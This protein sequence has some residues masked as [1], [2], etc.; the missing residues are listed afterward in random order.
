MDSQ[1]DK[2][3]STLLEVLAK[4]DVRKAAFFGSLVT[5]EATEDSDVDLLVEFEG[6]KSLLD[7]AGLKIELEEMLGRDVDVVTYASLHPLLRER[8]LSEQQLIL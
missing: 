1:I 3:K 5:S 7:L 4:H 6:N 8:I 2:M